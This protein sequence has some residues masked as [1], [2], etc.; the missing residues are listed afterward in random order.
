MDT[1]A[2]GFWAG[3]AIICSPCRGQNTCASNSRRAVRL[4]QVGDVRI[5]VVELMDHVLSTYDRAISNYT[6]EVFKRNSIDLVLNS[7]VASIDSDKVC[8]VNKEG[9][10]EELPF[11]ACVWATGD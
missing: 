1:D 8:I 5:R 9:E 4:V 10:Q 3:D 11:G 2:P 6:A 7:R